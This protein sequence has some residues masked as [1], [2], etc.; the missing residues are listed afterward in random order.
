MAAMARALVI[1]AMTLDIPFIAQ[2]TMKT[3][4]IFVPY[5]G[6]PVGCTRFAS[7]VFTRLAFIGTNSSI[8]DDIQLVRIRD[9]NKIQ[10]NKLIKIDVMF[11]GNGNTLRADRNGLTN[12]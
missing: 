10:S 8:I 6:T 5:E 7:V 3:L 1:V 12:V 11:Q 2:R 4:L 9:L